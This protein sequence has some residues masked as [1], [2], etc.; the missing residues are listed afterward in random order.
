MKATVVV[1]LDAAK[2]KAAVIWFDETKHHAPVLIN[3]L[4]GDRVSKMIDFAVQRKI[5]LIT[6]TRICESLHKNAKSRTII[7]EKYFLDVA[8]ILVVVMKSDGTKAVITNQLLDE[9]KML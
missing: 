6:N 3:K 2:T 7:P 4:E 1:L 8:E 5:A 9:I